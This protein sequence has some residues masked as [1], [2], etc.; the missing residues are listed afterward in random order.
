MVGLMIVAA[1]I[2]IYYIHKIIILGI[3]V[4]SKADEFLDTVYS[5]ISEV[6]ETENFR[7]DNLQFG[8]SGLQFIRITGLSALKSEF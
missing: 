3:V 8:K 2:D 5:A 7:S 6:Q 4:Q 1:K